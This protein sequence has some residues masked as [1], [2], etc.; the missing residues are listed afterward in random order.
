MSNYDS[1]YVSGARNLAGIFLD[2]ESAHDALTELH[3]AG[4]RRVW[5]GV[6]RAEAGETTI[7]VDAKERAKAQDFR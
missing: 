6:T 5:L 7:D 2:R 3:H 1:T 4:F